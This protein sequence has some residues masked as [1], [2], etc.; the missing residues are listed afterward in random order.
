MTSDER[1]DPQQQAEEQLTDDL[2]LQDETTEQVRGGG[3]N[4][5]PTENLSLNFGKVKL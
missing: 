3:G 2:E 1:T 4:D 5:T